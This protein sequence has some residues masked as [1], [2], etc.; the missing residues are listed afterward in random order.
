MLRELRMRAEDQ[1]AAR[2]APLADAHIAV[3]EGA[4]GKVIVQLPP[5]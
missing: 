4:I 5:P 2:A 3:E 1:G